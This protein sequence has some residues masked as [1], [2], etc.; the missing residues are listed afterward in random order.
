[1]VERELRLENPVPTGFFCE[2]QPGPDALATNKKTC[3][4]QAQRGEIQVVVL[5]AAAGDLE[6]PQVVS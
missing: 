2:C 6:R 3:D 4:L 5:P 1:M